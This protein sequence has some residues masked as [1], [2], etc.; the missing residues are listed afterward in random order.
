MRVMV[1]MVALLLNSCVMVD[2]ETKPVEEKYVVKYTN[3]YVNNLNWELLYMFAYVKSVNEYAVQHGWNPPKTA[4]LCR[5]VEWPK[6]LPLPQFRPSFNRSNPRSFEIEL[7]DYV[8]VVKRVYH[9]SRK[10]LKDAE[11]VQRQLC[12]Y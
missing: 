1:V 11:L 4:P 10:D 3:E 5:L 8:K 12:I 2:R 9:D 7:A 6:L